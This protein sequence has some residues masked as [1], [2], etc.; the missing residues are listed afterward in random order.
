MNNI[1]Y[2]KLIISAIYDMPILLQS[3]KKISI[4]SRQIMQY[5]LGGHGHNAV[6]QSED[7][8]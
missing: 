2:I 3:M 5:P 6:N 8:Y 1:E 4:L 7:Y